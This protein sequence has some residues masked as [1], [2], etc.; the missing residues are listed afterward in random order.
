MERSRS[1]SPA[2]SRSPS[3]SSQPVA[4]GAQGTIYTWQWVVPQYS[5]PMTFSRK[6][7]TH[8][9][10]DRCKQKNR[11]RRFTCQECLSLK[12]YDLC[13]ECINKAPKV[14]PGH[15]FYPLHDF[16]FVWY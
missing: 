6:L 15:H 11:R 12:P 14:H 7:S 5:W 10:C 8:W 3:P 13:I 1:P 9:R 4:K 2:K 16:K